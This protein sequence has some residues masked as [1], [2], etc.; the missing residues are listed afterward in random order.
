MN[1]VNLFF[2][3]LL[4]AS[5][6]AMTEMPLGR[7]ALTIILLVAAVSSVF[8]IA[9]SERRSTITSTSLCLLVVLMLSIWSPTFQLPSEM[10]R[11]SIAL[12]IWV[13]TLVATRLWPT[14]EPM[15]PPSPALSGAVQPEDLF[16][17]AS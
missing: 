1:A 14:T 4:G 7:Y 12:L 13:L 8:V 17:D 11:L 6:G 2:S 5:L 9:Y 15:S 3:A 10:Q 16:L